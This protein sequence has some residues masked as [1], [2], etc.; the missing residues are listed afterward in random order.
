MNTQ[1]RKGPQNSFKQKSKRLRTV[2]SMGSA[3]NQ[4]EDRVSD[5][6]DRSVA[7]D[8]LMRDALKNREGM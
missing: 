6:E 1:D 3:A 2:E 8:Q 7:D 4:C 5:L